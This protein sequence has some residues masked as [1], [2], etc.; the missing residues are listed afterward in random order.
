LGFLVVA[1][2]VFLLGLDLGE[3]EEFDGVV[4]RIEANEG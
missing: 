4:L 3:D 1:V 2:L